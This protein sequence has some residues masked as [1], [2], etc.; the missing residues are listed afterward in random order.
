MIGHFA[1]L[2]SGSSGNAA[3]LQVG[4][5]GLLIDFGFPPYLIKNALFA[6]GKSWHDVTHAVLTHTHGDHWNRDTL[7][8]FRRA[9]I[10]LIAHTL[11][12]DQLSA[13]ESYQ[14]LKRAELIRE[15]HESQPLTLAAGL[16][17]TPV[18]IP[19]DAEPSYGFR[20]DHVDADGQTWSLGYASDVGQPT[21]ALVDAFVEVDLLALEF[22]HDVQ[23]QL[24]SRRHNILIRRVLGPSGHLSNAQAASVTSDV[25]TRSTAN[26]LR[27]LLQ[28]HLSR[29]CNTP[30]HARIAA[31]AVLEQHKSTAKLI[32]CEQH[33]PTALIPIMPRPT[34][35]VEPTFAMPSPIRVQ[36]RLPGWDAAE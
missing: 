21:Q 29:E 27:N 26:R 11:H 15:Y 28:L 10:T 17:L 2:G 6:L 34:S 7:E 35:H 30:E 33:L 32:T 13:Q 22:N 23:M 12:H 5:V 8:H 20:I 9:N 3:F 31:N 19:H 18:R 1:V 24:D 36:P 4:P 16:T 25:L 14:P